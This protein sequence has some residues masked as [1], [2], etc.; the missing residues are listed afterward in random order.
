MYYKKTS[1]L[2]FHLFIFF[3]FSIYFHALFEVYLSQSTAIA[4]KEDE[5]NHDK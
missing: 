1:C 2:S 3:V 4:K 5:Q